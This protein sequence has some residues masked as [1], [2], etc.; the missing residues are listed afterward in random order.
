MQQYFVNNHNTA[1][2]KYEINKKCFYREEECFALNIS[3]EPGAPRYLLID[4]QCVSSEYSVLVFL[5]I[6]DGKD[7]FLVITVSRWLL[8]LDK[9]QLN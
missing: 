1:C 2:W 5:D 3:Q 7:L 8:G 6:S 4:N 9:K